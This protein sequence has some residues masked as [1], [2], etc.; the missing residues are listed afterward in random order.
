M[1]DH[2][3]LDLLS[4]PLGPEVITVHVPGIG[5]VLETPGG[6]WRARYTGSRWGWVFY[7]AFDG[8]WESA[9][10]DLP[11]GVDHVDRRDDAVRILEEFAGRYGDDP[12]WQVTRP[13]RRLVDA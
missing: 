5:R 3:Q 2:V 7:R 6:G 13:R 1:H 10:P 11:H 9:E 8:G 12:D 4:D